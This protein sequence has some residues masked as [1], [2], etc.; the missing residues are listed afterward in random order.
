MKGVCKGLEAVDL[1]GNGWC[2]SE[3]QY[4]ATKAIEAW[5]IM[6]TGKKVVSRWISPEYD[7]GIFRKWG[8]YNERNG[9][10]AGTS[11]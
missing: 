11:P 7:Q 6:A 10:Q 3:V 4:R 5:L 9:S 2:F 8:V 1:R